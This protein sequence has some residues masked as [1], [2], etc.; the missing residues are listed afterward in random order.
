MEPQVS[1]SENTKTAVSYELLICSDPMALP[2]PIRRGADRIYEELRELSELL[3]A[4]HGDLFR[5]RWGLDSHFPHMTEQTATKFDIPKNTVQ[6]MLN[7]SLWNIA[8]YAHYRELP[9]IRELLG[10]D[11]T[12]WAERAWSQADQRWGNQY[13]AFSEAVLLLAVG[14]IP[15]RDAHAAARQRMIEVGVARTNRWGKPLNAQERIDDARSALDRILQQVIWLSN[16]ARQKDLGGFSNQRPLPSFACSKTGVFRSQKLGR[17]VQFDSTLELRLLQQLELDDRV[18][19]Y[20]EQPVE[21]NYALD[22]ETRG[23]TPDIAVEL[24]DGRVFI[25]EAKPLERLGEFTNVKKWSALAAWCADSGFGFWVGSPERSLVEH[26]RV[27]PNPD[28]HELVTAEVDAGPVTAGDY[29][30]L[31]RLVGYEQL[32]VVATQELLEWRPGAGYVK[33]SETTDRHEMK[34]FWGLMEPHA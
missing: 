10:D 28:K 7:Q 26:C 9:A 11:Q 17:L 20:Q 4:R 6:R 27:E 13:A 2:F 15:V 16:P 8:R 14:G 23:Y 24:L 3:P 25:V 31:V 33:R 32:G 1:D 30:A 18:A 22:G 29:E 21:L 5:H 19:S 34:G 12:R